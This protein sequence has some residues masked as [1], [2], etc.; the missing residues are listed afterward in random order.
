MN[1]TVTIE[2]M[3]SAA[4]RFLQNLAD[5]SLIRFTS[6]TSTSDQVT[7]LINKLCEENDTSLDPC[8]MAAQVE[9]IRKEDW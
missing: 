4:L 3:D 1:S 7:A 2:I 6:E 8:I 5:I 9:V